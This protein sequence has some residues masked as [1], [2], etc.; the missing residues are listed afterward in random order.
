MV[1]G[2]VVATV[3]EVIGHDVEKV[4]DGVDRG[5]GTACEG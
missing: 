5:D 1:L 2:D 3:H 4:H